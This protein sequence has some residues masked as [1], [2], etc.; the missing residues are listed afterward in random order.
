MLSLN[1]FVDAFVNPSDMPHQSYLMA[2]LKPTPASISVPVWCVGNS[3]LQCCHNDL[4]MNVTAMT[5]FFFKA[6]FLK[7]FF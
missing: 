6:F 2:W 3:A 1:N 5:A 7:L 4:S